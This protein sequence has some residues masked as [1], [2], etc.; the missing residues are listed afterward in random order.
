M[1]DILK[2][3]DGK[4]AA[5]IEVNT[6]LTLSLKTNLSVNSCAEHS[7]LY[8]KSVLLDIDALMQLPY[9]NSFTVESKLQ[10]YDFYN[11]REYE[12]S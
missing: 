1:V 7:R 12:H 9:D 2:S 4:T 11:R 10:R 3:E 6:K 8:L 5:M